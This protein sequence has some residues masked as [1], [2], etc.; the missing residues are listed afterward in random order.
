M[1][2]RL[3]IANALRLAAA[4]IDGSA[5]RAIS[6]PTGVITLPEQPPLSEDDLA[7]LRKSFEEKHIGHAIGWWH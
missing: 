3:R 4:V 7:K 1:T 6:R 2:K 5:M